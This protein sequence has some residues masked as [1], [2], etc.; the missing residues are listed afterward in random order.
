MVKY[1][2][3]IVEVM[4]K[5]VQLMANKSKSGLSH[6]DFETPFSL[7]TTDAAACSFTPTS[8]LNLPHSV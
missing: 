5:V 8:M 7:Q 2:L 6:Y 4:V 1:V 3:D